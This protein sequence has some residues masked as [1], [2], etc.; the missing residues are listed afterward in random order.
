MNSLRYFFLLITIAFCSFTLKAQ[1]EDIVV[2]EFQENF[3]EA[4]KH[5]A[6]ENYDKAIESLEK[7]AT[8][9]KDNPIIYFELG[10]NYF[11]QKKYSEALQNYLEANR[12]KPKDKWV[13]SGLYDVYYDFKDYNQALNIINELVLL[14]KKFREDQV[15]LYMYTKQYD[16]A[17]AL[18]KILDEEIGSTTERDAFKRQIFTDSKYRDA[19]KE[20]LLS[21][22]KK[23]PKTES[24]YISLI[25]LYSESNQEE[26]AFET[27]KQLEKNI[28]DSEWAQVGLFKFYLNNNK[29]AE[30]VESMH[31]VLKNSSI[32]NKIKVKIINEFLIYNTTHPETDKELETA[33]AQIDEEDMGKMAKEV[34]KYYQRINQEVKA[35][36]YFKIT[37]SHIP[38]DLDTHLLLLQSYLKMQDFKTIA[39]ESE[40][41]LEIYPLQ[42][43]LFYLAGM[44]N[45]KIGRFKKAKDFLESGLDMVVDNLDLEINFYLEIIIACDGLG[46]IKGKEINFHKYKRL[47][48]Q[49]K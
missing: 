9:Q 24:N 13:L 25:Y 40:N 32:N 3:F 47:M 18:I 11:F 2:D 38:N 46:D 28:P 44:S 1:E 4:L 7:C 20:F 42:P 33:L 41:L 23:Y 16:K 5:K 8:L 22:I 48:S 10:K 29:T 6:V 27:A 17:L 12:L 45:N 21:Q 15:S 39:V 43:D 34:A 30:A 31:K 36:K 26:K 35:I 37:L 14:D 49:K 19:E